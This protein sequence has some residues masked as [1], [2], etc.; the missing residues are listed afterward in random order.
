LE[1]KRK[2]PLPFFLFLKEGFLFLFL[3]IIIKERV[4][5][6]SQLRLTSSLEQA[7]SMDWN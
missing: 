7:V 6:R 5:W 1:T 2:S 3:V 4:R